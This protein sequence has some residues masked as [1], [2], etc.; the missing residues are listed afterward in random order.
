MTA[1][2]TSVGMLPVALGWA[3]GLERLAGLAVVAIFGLLV[4]TVLTLIYVPVFYK[5]FDGGATRM[6]H[7]LHIT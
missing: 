1:I 4:S 6:R 3:I 2:G 5:L 7:L